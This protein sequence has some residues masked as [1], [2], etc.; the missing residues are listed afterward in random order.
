MYA[1]DEMIELGLKEGQS[2]PNDA[3]R[4]VAVTIGLCNPRVDD[5]DKLI[6]ICQAILQVPEDRIKLVTLEDLIF[7][8]KV[9]YLN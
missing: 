7:E 9:P 8:F 5:R 4:K 3:Y 6:E 1:F 2:W